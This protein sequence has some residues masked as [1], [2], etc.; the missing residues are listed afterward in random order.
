MG[1]VYNRYMI[2]DT[3]IFIYIYWYIILRFK[4]ITTLLRCVFSYIVRACERYVFA[5]ASGLC[6][7]TPS[8]QTLVWP[9][10]HILNHA[11]LGVLGQR[12]HLYCLYSDGTLWAGQEG[13]GFSAE[14]SPCAAKRSWLVL[15]GCWEATLSPGRCW[16]Y[17]QP[18]RIRSCHVWPEFS[19]VQWWLE[20]VTVSTDRI[21]KRNPVRILSLGI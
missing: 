14:T 13:L 6:W 3:R 17:L 18:D 15:A 11:H 4:Y 2:Y 8:G 12:L 21:A 7:C 1:L 10:R 5:Q 19:P 16:P 20:S 9:D